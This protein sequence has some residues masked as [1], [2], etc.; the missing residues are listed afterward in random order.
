MEIEEWCEEQFKGKPEYT[1]RTPRMGI[2]GINVAKKGEKE[3]EEQRELRL[4]KALKT[5]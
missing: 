1:R 3:T 4:G 5:F 2:E